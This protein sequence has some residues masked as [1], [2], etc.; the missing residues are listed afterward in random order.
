VDGVIDRKQ[1]RNWKPADPVG[2]K[3]LAALRFDRRAWPGAVISPEGCRGKIAMDLLPELAH[4][5]V[6]DFFGLADRAND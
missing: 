3:G 6:Y 5:D 4:F 2:V 1:V